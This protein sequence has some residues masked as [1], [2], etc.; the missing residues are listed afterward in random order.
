MIWFKGLSQLTLI[1]NLSEEIDVVGEGLPAR[2]RQ[3]AGGERPAFAEGFGDGDIPSFLQRAKMNAEVAVGH[4]ERVAEFGEVQ[5]GGTSQECH[6]GH[7][8]P[9]VNDAIE[10]LKRCRV[11]ASFSLGSVNRR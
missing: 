2:G 9:F 10:L 11:H 4:A 1:N 6:Q 5:V 7:A 3:R 8:P